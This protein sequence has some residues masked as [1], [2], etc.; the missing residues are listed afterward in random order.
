MEGVL[1]SQIGKQ[2][3]SS[4]ETEISEEPKKQCESQL[5]VFSTQGLPYQLQITQ[6]L[7][8]SLCFLLLLKAANK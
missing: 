8:C 6:K 3:T 2:P 7:S 5:Y 1:T 4:I